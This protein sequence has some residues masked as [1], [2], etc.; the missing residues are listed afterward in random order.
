MRRHCPGS[1]RV[2]EKRKV[3]KQQKNK[4]SERESDLNTVS[5]KNLGNSILSFKKTILNKLG[6]RK[7]IEVEIG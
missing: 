6:K 3:S 5:H 7:K 4:Q 2:I 1:T